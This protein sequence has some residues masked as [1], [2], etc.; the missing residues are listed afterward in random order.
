MAAD[1]ERL[2]E[3]VLLGR[4]D[5]LFS[6]VTLED[7]AD[8]WCRYQ[9]RPHVYEVDE[10][11]PDAWA[12]L[13]LADPGVI[14]EPLI[15]ILLD[16]LI[17]RAPNDDV[18]EMV[19]AGPLEDFVKACD[20]DRLSWIEERAASSARFRQALARV[21]IWS[22]EM[23]TFARV[24]R[25]AGVKLTTPDK[26]AILDIVPGDLPGTVHITRNGLTVSEIE[27]EPGLVEDMIEFLKRHTPIRRHS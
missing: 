15:R 26:D 7:L 2:E 4:V 23:D 8:A 1:R 14:D 9:S 18:L 25:A 5:E 27:T 13:C 10:E 6:L 11:D 17:D 16:L 21:W 22:V 19:G 20:E 3:L 12:M 24:E